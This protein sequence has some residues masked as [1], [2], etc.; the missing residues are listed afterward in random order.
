MVATGALAGSPPPI[1]AGPMKGQAPPRG[2]ARGQ[3]SNPNLLYH[4]GPVMTSGAAVTPIYWGSG[5]SSDPQN[6]EGWLDTFY[7]GMSSSSYAGTNTEYTQAGGGHVGTSFTV[8]TR[9]VDTSK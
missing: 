8:N 4:G 9:I 5:W 3:Q 7:R 6:K 1:K 2:Q